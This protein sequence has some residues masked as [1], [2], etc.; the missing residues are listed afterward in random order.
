MKSAGMKIRTFFAVLISLLITDIVIGSP[1]PSSSPS[2]SRN[3]R[4]LRVVQ[5][6]QGVEWS[7]FFDVKSSHFYYFCPKTGETSWSISLPIVTNPLANR[8]GETSS[9]KDYSHMHKSPWTKAKINSS[10]TFKRQNSHMSQS[11]YRKRSLP[12]VPIDIDTLHLLQDPAG[13]LRKLKFKTIFDNLDGI[14]LRKT[15]PLRLQAP[16]YVSYF[17]FDIEEKG[18]S[19]YSFDINIHDAS[20]FRKYDSD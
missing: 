9:A 19:F 15:F 8:K 3:F 11:R 17:L 4:A 18:Y 6:I 2:E 10:Y 13:K 1:L 20:Y 14:K 12:L 7:E 5:D 16:A